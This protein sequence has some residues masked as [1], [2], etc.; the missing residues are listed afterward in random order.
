MIGDDQPNAGTWVTQAE[1]AR[2]IGVNRATIK[3]WAENP[4]TGVKRRADGMVELGAAIMHNQRRNDAKFEA[5]DD[6]P[7]ESEKQVEKLIRDAG[8]DG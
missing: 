7:V 8:L 4:D 3:R 6:E 5:M 1:A 2:K